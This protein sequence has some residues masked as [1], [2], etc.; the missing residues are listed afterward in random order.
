MAYELISSRQAFPG[1]MKEGLL[2]K[3]LNG[4]ADPLSSV[5]PGIDAEVVSIV[6]Q[7][8]KKDP[9]DRYQDLVRMRNDL[10]RARVRIEREEELAAAAA[11]AE[12]G[13]TAVIG[14]HATIALD[15]QRPSAP[16]VVHQAEHALA[17]G[18]FRAALTLAGRSA[19][20]NP[21]DRSG[22]SIVARAE[23]ALLD[24]G[25][26][27]LQSGAPVRPASSVPAAPVPA[28]GV[29]PLAGVASGSV[30]RPG[31]GYVIW[32]AV[33][34]AVAALGIA[35]AALWLRN[36]SG[37]PAQ[38]ASEK[39]AASPQLPEPRP[40][41]PTP[42]AAAPT[43]PVPAP[44]VSSPAPGPA[45]EKPNA[46]APS[47]SAVPP[48]VAARDADSPAAARGS[49]A[50]GRRGEPE[51]RSPAGARSTVPPSSTVP[52]PAPSAPAPSAPAPAERPSGP[53]RAG[54]DVTAPGRKKYSEPAATGSGGAVGIELT[55]GT[56]GHV[57]D[58]RVVRS[59]GS[60][61]EPALAA[62]R[63]WEFDVTRGRNGEAVSVIYTVDVK[64]PAAPA[65]PPA[66]K[67]STPAAPPPAAPAKSSETG[68]A[69]APPPPDQQ[70]EIRAVLG[71]YKAAWESLNPDAI[72][73]VQAL[74]PGEV[75][76]LRRFMATANRYEVDWAVKSIVVDPS[77]RTAVAQ[78]AMVRRFVPKIGRAPGPQQASEVR[79]EKRG[80]TWVVV[81]VQ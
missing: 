28:S 5:V 72:A 67:P 1:T 17:S 31:G 23:A 71:R 64:V 3:I 38:V 60:L 25:R 26:L 19:A 7:A 11:A 14:E 61:D 48:E 80:D 41:P 6:E 50:R 33:A 8:L 59:S 66:A 29:P 18:N 24:R 15:A 44:P 36:P 49:T 45:T 43:Q 56:D 34:I 35:V 69:A 21:Q 13:E 52:P 81:S 63:Q 77:G 12:A 54:F 22:S 65:P 40:T 46:D 20:I 58:A 51:R 9:A 68:R 47:V 32:I 27:L 75:S 74:S 53:L 10:S 39:P 62:V 70:E 55:I 57:I 16:A 2:N 76:E 79:L 4:A 37:A 73:R 30:A 42:S 78:V